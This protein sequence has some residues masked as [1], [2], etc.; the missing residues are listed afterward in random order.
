MRRA[1]H[2]AGAMAGPQVS[3]MP[4]ALILN[5]QE[6]RPQPIISVATVVRNGASTLRRAIESVVG[7]EHPAVE[8]IVIDGGST[9]GTIEILREYDSAIAFWSSEPDR[10]IYDAM[11]KAA[12]RATGKWLFFL[13]AD[14]EIRIDFDSLISLLAKADAV[15]YGNVELQRNSEV[16]GETFSA[17]KLMQRNICHQAILYPRSVYANHSYSLTAG[18]LAD[19]QYNIE[20][21]GAATAFIYINVT[22]ARF[23]DEG[24]SAGNVAYFEPLKLAAIRRH[25]GLHYYLAKRVRNTLAS[26]M[27][28]HDESA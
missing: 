15:Y 8:Y 5:A 24:A 2:Q 28:G 10:G 6:G 25:F 1:T 14:D 12:A 13:G 19:H 20:V 22:I 3:M 21:W 9:D 26:L 18:V 27:K 7:A 17:W 11:N 16:Q 23:N 4:A